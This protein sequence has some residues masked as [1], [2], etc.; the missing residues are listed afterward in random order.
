ML[1]V[2]LKREAS[3]E[4][5]AAARWYEAQTEGF[6][7]ALLD[8]IESALRT[9][10]ESPRKWP[11]RPGAKSESQLRRFILSRFPYAIGY[12]AENTRVVVFAVAHTRRR[13]DYWFGRA[14]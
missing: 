3:A 10:A 1:P 8:E 4:V 9:I 5:T 6:G 12:R 14:R 7:V 2:I 13:P 11:R